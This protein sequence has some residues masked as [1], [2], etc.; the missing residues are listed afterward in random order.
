MCRHARARSPGSPQG[1]PDGM[2]EWLAR[3]WQAWVETFF[4]QS[5]GVGGGGI[6]DGAFPEWAASLK[7][8]LRA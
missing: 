4:F 2:Y 3:G 1:R 7:E 5:Q 6:P 8:P